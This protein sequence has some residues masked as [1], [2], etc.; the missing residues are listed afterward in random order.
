MKLDP[1][2]AVLVELEGDVVVGG[3]LPLID[4]IVE[5]A[6][7][8]LVNGESEAGN[9]TPDFL[10][11]GMQVIDELMKKWIPLHVELGRPRR[12][13]E[14]REEG[15]DINIETG[16]VIRAFAWDRSAV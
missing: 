8:I 4:R 13:H 14:C 12:L 10:K 15:A 3:F 9:S 16:L 7:F 11:T 5:P 1:P 2:Y 6:Y